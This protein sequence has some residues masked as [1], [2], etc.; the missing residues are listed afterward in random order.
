MVEQKVIQY[1]PGEACQWG[2]HLV[3]PTHAGRSVGRPADEGLVRAIGV[4]ALTAST[5]NCIIGAG[6]FVLPAVAAQGLGPAAVVS[7]V[8]CAMAMGLVVLCFAAAGSRVGSS[9]GM[10]AYTEAA[11]GPFPGFV[12]GAVHWFAGGVVASAS[13]ANALVDTLAEIVPFIAT[14]AG[15][16]GVILAAYGGLAAAN[17][18]GVQVAARLIEGI[19]LAKLAPLL[20]LACGGLFLLEPGNLAWPGAPTLSAVGQSALLVI[21]AFAGT[22]VAVTPGGEIR[23]PA[24]TLPRAILLA[25]SLATI[26]YLALQVTAQGVLGSQLARETNAPLAATAERIIGS[27]GRLLL[28]LGGTISMLGYLSADALATPRMLYAF[29]RDGIGPRRL[30]AVHS[31][32]RTP[33]VAILVNQGVSALLAIT[34]SFRTLLILANL[35]TLIVYFGVALA[36]IELDRRD[37]RTDGPPFR[38]P[39]GAAIPLLACLVILW[40]ASHADRA[41][42]LAAGAMVLVAAGAFWLN[43]LA[44]RRAVI[45]SG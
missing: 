14:P 10:Y 23:N 3:M 2:I 32:F 35:G 41:D 1:A 17:I 44:R 24:R 36:S 4:R 19:T 8:V 30:A 33:Y 13:V 38:L 27:S 22:E 5:L 40:L 31:R 11:F 9:G 18:R 16:V 45:A 15:R 25:L 29:G 7:Y 43:A 39:G 34:G 42:G 21:F 6:I 12:I 20:L 26:L 28:L 37:V